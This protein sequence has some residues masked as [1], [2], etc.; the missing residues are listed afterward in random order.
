MT[1]DTKIMVLNHLTNMEA[2]ITTLKKIVRNDNKVL[3]DSVY[4][5]E[6][7]VHMLHTEVAL[8]KEK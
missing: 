6:S 2:T 8:D 5:I 1:E 7:A 3:S 4:E